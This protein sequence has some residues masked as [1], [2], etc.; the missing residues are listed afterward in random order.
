MLYKTLA[1]SGIHYKPADFKAEVHFLGQIVG[2]SNIIEHDA[3]FI[4]AYFEIGD[5][6]RYLSSQ[7]TIQT[8][9]CFVDEYNFAC[10]AHPFDL[11]LTTE[12]L[13]GW[14]RLIVRLWKLD[15]TNKV[16]LVSYGTTILPNTSGY[17]EIEF[18]TW[19]LKG[20]VT[21]E[22]LCF[23]MGSKPLMNTSDPVNSNLDKRKAIISKPGPKVHLTVEV[24]LRNFSFHSLSGAKSKK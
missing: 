15:D 3:V 12:N 20:N 11:H 6:W 10:F 5:Q 9:S 21:Q 13:Y 2:A 23:F 19:S 7:A 17:H 14:P 16:D 22:T 18:E 8:Q 4:E 1:N 24:I